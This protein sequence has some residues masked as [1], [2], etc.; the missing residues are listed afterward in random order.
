[1]LGLPPTLGL[2][3]VFPH[4]PLRPVTINGG[5]VM[6]AWYDIVAAPE[7]FRGDVEHIREAA[8][9]LQQ[10]IRRESQRGIA[11]RRIVVAGFS[12]GGAIALY[13][14]LRYPSRL[15]GV[16]A[17]ST[18]LPLADTLAAERAA[19]NDDIPLFMAHGTYDPL[20]ALARAEESRTLLTRLGYHIT[21]QTYPMPHSV[22]PEEIV[23][24][25]TWLS[26]VFREGK[27]APS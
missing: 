8:A 3:F 7:G 26:A 16:L 14:A 23:Q 5:A 21:W 24:I 25:G 20:I 18:Y 17:L 4:A 15:A 1:M 6:R 9:I 2:R 13:T 10:L 27:P 12:Q 22:C 19:C 11:A